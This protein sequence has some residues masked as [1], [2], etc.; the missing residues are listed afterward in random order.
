[1]PRLAMPGPLGP[2]SGIPHRPSPF[3]G[4][5][6]PQCGGRFRP[7]RSAGLC[8]ACAVRRHRGGYATAAYP[9]SFRAGGRDLAMVRH[10]PRRS[11]D[12]A[13][14]TPVASQR[15]GSPT[16]RWVVPAAVS[17]LGP[18]GRFRRRTGTSVYAPGHVGPKRPV[19]P[20]R[21][22]S[23][24]A[25]RRLLSP[26]LRFSKRMLSGRGSDLAQRAPL[27]YP[28]TASVQARRA[29]RGGHF[30]RSLLIRSEPRHK[31]RVR[32]WPTATN[33]SSCHRCAWPRCVFAPQRHSVAYFCTTKGAFP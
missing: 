12:S 6:R 32:S 18:P 11:R 15:S 27:L 25:V 20:L 19:S 29:A 2:G 9:R 1:M 8:T 30:P 33:T 3:P 23:T 22:A 17:S 14:F 13:W 10:G 31:L 7:G 26:T 24:A 16:R 5:I 21:P 28:R 4:A